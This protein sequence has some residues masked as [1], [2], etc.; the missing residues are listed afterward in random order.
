MLA[1][2]PGPGFLNITQGISSTD[3]GETNKFKGQRQ[4]ELTEWVTQPASV[5]SG[6]IRSLVRAGV[7]AHDCN[8]STH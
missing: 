1:L 5:S 4:R 6:G 8:V 2:S 7:V 3:N